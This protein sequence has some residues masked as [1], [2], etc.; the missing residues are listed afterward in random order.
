MTIEG[1][2]AW[3]AAV[4]HL[5]TVAGLG[6]ALV[7]PA[8]AGG[9]E[10]YDDPFAYCR[11]V[12]TVDAPDDRYDGPAIPDLLAEKLRAAVGAPEDAP[13]GLFREGAIW[14]CM[15]GAVFACTVG[16]N[17]PC[18]TKADSGRTPSEPMRQFC[19]E[20]PDAPVIPAVVTG[21]A[22]VYGWRCAGGEAVA[23]GPPRAIDSAGFLADI[24]YRLEPD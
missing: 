2:A 22:T 5:L 8:L 17:L 7:S 16:A 19:R 12:G 23:E 6:L 9:A 4:R 13:L 20:Q 24:W 10:T 15:D 21:R 1:T 18:A 11:A 14:R 3:R